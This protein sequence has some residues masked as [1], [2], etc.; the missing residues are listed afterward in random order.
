M[1]AYDGE[2]S[3][4]R[5]LEVAAEL[6]LA[7]RSRGAGGSMLVCSVVPTSPLGVT[8]AWDNDSVH[9][10]LL[11]E[12][13][14]ALTGYGIESTTVMVHGDPS[15]ELDRVAQEHGCD[16]I[17]V[18]THLGAS[19]SDPKRSVSADLA[20]HARTPVVVIAR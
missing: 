18:G 6:L 2:K 13:A 1:L 8:A 15:T 14:A 12:A 7:V 16:V 4:R 3:G 10:R 9:T 20:L 5:A 19:S 17:V 11:A